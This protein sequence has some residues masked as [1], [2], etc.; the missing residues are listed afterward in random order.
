[1]SNIFEMFDIGGICHMGSDKIQMESDN[2][3]SDKFC[4]IN[5]MKSG[6]PKKTVM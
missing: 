3:F 4:E 6:I 5:I 1:M 2:G